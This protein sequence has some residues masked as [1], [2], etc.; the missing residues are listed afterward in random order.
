MGA[1]KEILDFIMLEC[2]PQERPTLEMVSEHQLKIVEAYNERRADSLTLKNDIYELV[3]ECKNYE[4]IGIKYCAPDFELIIMAVLQTAKDWGITLDETEI[5]R[6]EGVSLNV[7]ENLAE[8]IRKD[9]MGA[10]AGDTDT[11]IDLEKKLD[12]VPHDFL[13]TFFDNMNAYKS[14]MRESKGDNAEGVAKTYKRYGKL[15][16][17][18]NKKV[19][20]YWKHLHDELKI[21][22]FKLPTFQGVCRTLEA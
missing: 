9:I 20:E 21:I 19:T 10:N 15:K 16:I 14:C 18:K 13:I 8:Y 4:R 2:N 3:T 12:K 17:N 11:D 7:I 22:T 1:R 5:Q 6:Y